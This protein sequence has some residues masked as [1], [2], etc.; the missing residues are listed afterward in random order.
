MQTVDK[1][2]DIFK[3]GHTDITNNNY[4]VGK[5]FK[6]GITKNIMH[7]IYIIRLDQRI[8]AL[9]DTGNFFSENF[10]HLVNMYGLLDLYILNH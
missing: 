1:R 6:S 10:T 9:A 7:I 3:N 8:D 2:Y 5:P 4:R